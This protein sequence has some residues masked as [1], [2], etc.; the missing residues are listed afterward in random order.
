MEIILGKLRPCFIC[1]SHQKCHFVS[2]DNIHPICKGQNYQFIL[3]LDLLDY[4]LA[5]E[6]AILQI[7]S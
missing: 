2:R 3:A 6:K 7:V 1:H 5:D 4:S